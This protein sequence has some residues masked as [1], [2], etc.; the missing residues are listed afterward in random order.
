MRAN[1]VY[2][3]VCVE[4]KLLGGS[5]SHAVAQNLVLPL[6]QLRRPVRIPVLLVLVGFV[7]VFDAAGTIG[8]DKSR[9]R[10]RFTPKIL[11]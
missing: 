11:N 7:L 1:G 5:H 8:R 10:R 2:A 4:E 3:G 6:R 9:V